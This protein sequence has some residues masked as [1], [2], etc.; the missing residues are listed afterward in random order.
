MQKYQDAIQD[1]HGNAI[2][3]ALVTV[4]VYGTL[5]LATIYSDN[6]LTVVPSSIVTTDTDG[7]FF[8][9]ADNGRYTLSISA[10]NFAAE[11][12]TD[13]T[14]FDQTDAGIASVK[15]YGAVGNGVT[16]DTAAIQ[17][18]IDAVYSANGG[19]I[20][21]PAGT[22]KT[23][24]AIYMKRYVTLRGPEMNISPAALYAGTSV[25]GGVDGYA[26]I[27]PTD[28]VS[29]AAII[30]DFSL[31]TREARPYGCKLINLLVD[32]D[33]M[34]GTKDGILINKVTAG[35]G[36]FDTGFA[37]DANELVS[38]SVINAPRY[39]VNVSG[40]A[41]TQRI[42]LS[43]SECR[44]AFSGNHGIYLEKT[45]DCEVKYT[46]SF[47]NY[48]SGLYSTD[49]ATCRILFCDFFNNGQYGSVTN[50]GHGIADDSTDMRY[51][52]CHID[53][54]YRHGMAFISVSNTTK[55]KLTRVVDCRITSNGGDSTTGTYDNVNIGSISGD[56]IYG[57]D[58]VACRIGG[59][60]HNA[61]ATARV[62]YQIN[63][64]TAS[65]QNANQIVGCQFSAS[66]LYNTANVLS[67]AAWQQSIISGSYNVDGNVL[68]T[69]P[70]ALAAW[71]GDAS[72]N[73]LRGANF[74]KTA[75]VAGA[76]ISGLSG[77]ASG[78]VLGREIWILIDDANTGVDFTFTSLKGNSGVDLAAPCT[79]TMLHAKNYDGTNWIVDVIKP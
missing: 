23:T 56:S 11:L 16:D 28:A 78:N 13:V 35:Q 63:Q 57:I 39:G 60:P 18:A 1:V 6:G 19:E 15:D 65:S 8:F 44:V 42:N 9:Y 75:N 2:P 73:V 38:V 47:G 22:Y 37:S 25:E 45:Y 52:G 5:T 29:T 10:T 79:G 41:P 17:A 61:V 48:G 7:Q 76:R 71:T 34:T 51:T 21:V 4:Y 20:I 14:L 46:F 77:G 40:N 27:V 30:F 53:N 74:Y 49:A 32:C 69:K 24:A 67:D 36:P 54:N 66:D 26:K 33:A 31:A 72:Q 55:N 62:G 59:S 70:Y 68:A 43:M 3:D 12:K 64:T 58:F 50:G